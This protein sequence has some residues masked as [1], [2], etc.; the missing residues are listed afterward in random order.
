MDKAPECYISSPPQKISHFS[1]QV[2]PFLQSF[3]A[4][5]YNFCPA[6]ISY[7]VFNMKGFTALVPLLAPGLFITTAIAK[8]QFAGVNIAG[9]DF[10]C[11]D[12]VSAATL[13]FPLALFLF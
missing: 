4:T 10:G 8:V 6:K 3:I 7:T 5:L 12:D 1:E 9:C 2:I 11:T 13:R